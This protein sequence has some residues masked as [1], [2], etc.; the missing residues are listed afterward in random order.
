MLKISKQALM[1][2]LEIAEHRG[3]G[4]RCLDPSWR[5]SCIRADYY[6]IKPNKGEIGVTV[7]RHEIVR[8]Y[9]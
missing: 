2:A 9:Q 1:K 7:G 6:P 8:W 4:L 5:R 3:V